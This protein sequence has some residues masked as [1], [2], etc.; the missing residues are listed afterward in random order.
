MNPIKFGLCGLGRIG[1]I[2]C[3]CFSQEK[4]KYKL[5]RTVVRWAGE[6]KQKENLPDPISGLVSRA[7]REI[8]SGNIS[9]ED[10]EKLPTL[11]LSAAASSAPAAPPAKPTKS[12]KTEE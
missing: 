2:H 11:T 3:R 6:I 5:V 7:L 4:D 9:I 1:V 12:D 8:L 10:V